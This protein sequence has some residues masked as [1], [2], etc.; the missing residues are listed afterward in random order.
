MIKKKVILGS[1]LAIAD[2]VSAALVTTVVTR[3]NI[4]AKP[5]QTMV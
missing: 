2:N 3:S 4:F 1:Y 5:I